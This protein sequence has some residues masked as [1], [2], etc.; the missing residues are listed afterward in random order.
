M[1]QVQPWSSRGP[2]AQAQ[3]GGKTFL[4]LRLSQHDRVDQTA[5]NATAII[6]L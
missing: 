1:N 5:S 4:G 3:T 6:Y 2:E